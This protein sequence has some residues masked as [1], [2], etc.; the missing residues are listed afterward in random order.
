MKMSRISL[1]TAITLLVL[2]AAT[3]TPAAAQGAKPITFGKTK[4]YTHES[5]IFSIDYPSA[6]KIE[7]RSAESKGDTIVQFTDKTGYA[8]LRVDIGETS[9]EWTSTELAAQVTK[10]IKERYKSF[11]KYSAGAAKKI[12]DTKAALYFK[13]TY[14]NTPMTGDAIIEWHGKHISVIALVIPTDQYKKNKTAAYASIDSFKLRQSGSE[15][16]SDLVEYEHPDGVF[17]ISYPEGWE[18]DDRS[19]KGEAVVVFENPE[20]VSFLMIEAYQRDGD[21]MTESELVEKLD[22]VVDSSIGENVEDYDPKDAEGIN[23]D[24]ASKVFT[25]TIKDAD[26]NDVQ[27]IG[28][29]LLQE[30]GALLSYT[31]II[32]PVDAFDASSDS[33]KEII[34]SLQVDEEAEF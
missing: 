16:I 25:F 6:W 29:M 33:L 8:V 5:G 23:D 15:T 14:E 31:R 2:N 26:E 24:A 22:S 30:H 18:I 20:G 11:K 12:N 21:D 7:D 4:T 27:V 17:T 3:A 10:L 28:I 13:F 1:V 32:L 9:E 34:D 19:T